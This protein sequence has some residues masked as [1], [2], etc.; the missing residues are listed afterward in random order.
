MSSI[1]SL[2]ASRVVIPI[3]DSTG[4][5]GLSFWISVFFC[6]AS[7]LVN[8]AYIFLRTFIP[9]ELPLISV[10]DKAVT[11]IHGL[12]IKRTFSWDSLKNIS[13]Q[14]LMLSGSQILQSGAANSFSNS[15]AEI[16][17]WKGN[18]QDVAGFM[19]T[20][21]RTIQ[22]LMGPIVGFAIKSHG[23]RFHYVTADLLFTHAL[24]ALVFS[25]LAGSI[26][27]L[28]LQTCITL[29]T[30]DQYE[31]GTAFGLCKSFT[32]SQTTIIEVIYGVLQDGTKDMEY[33]RVLKLG[34]AIKALGFAIGVAHIIVDHK[35]D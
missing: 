28:P 9:R 29:L 5:Y 3:S 31:L 30:A 8:I 13:W 14:Y 18:Q 1:V 11:T 19:A 7:L 21:Q 20:G 4:W 34:I 15:A 24:V 2:V 32:N 17:R 33:D 23:H 35:L 16:T 22:F 6:A 25:A 26:N 27:C 12:K 10:G